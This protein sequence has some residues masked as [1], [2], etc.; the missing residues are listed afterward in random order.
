M[1]LQSFLRAGAAC[2]ILYAISPTAAFAEEGDTTSEE[3][4]EI[5]VIG[6]K[7]QQTIEASPATQASIDAPKIA[8]TINAVNVE[9]TLKYLPSLVVRKRHI[10]DTQ[11]PIATR[12]SGLGASARSLIYADGVLLSALIANNNTQGS[13]RWGFVGPDEVARID[14]QYGP[15]SAAYSG[16]SIGAVVNIT[17]RLPDSLEISANLLTNVQD[18][19]LYGTDSIYPTYQFA[20]AVG[21]R[22]GPLALFASVSRTDSKGH[23]LSYVTANRPAAPSAAGTATIG[24]YDDLN[25]TGAAIRVLGAGGIEHNV[26][27]IYKFKAAL[28]LSSNVRLTYVGGVFVDDTDS[29][30]QSFLTSQATGNAVYS[31]SLNLGGYAYSLSSTAFSSGIYHRSARHITHA[32]SATGNSSAFDWQVIA[33]QYDYDKDIQRTPTTAPPG[34]FTGGAG[35]IVDLDGTGWRTLDAKAAWRAGNNTL[36]AGGH[37]DR[38]AINSNRYVTTDWLVGNKGTLNLTS[39][40]KTRTAALWI[41]DVLQI[42]ETLSMTVGGRY[43]WWR[44]YDGVNFSLSPALSVNQPERKA[45][46]FSPKVSIEWR[47]ADRWRTRLSFGK[48]YRFPTVGELYQAITTGSTLT[49]PNP[50]LRPEKALSEELA[51]EYVTSSGTARISLFNESITDALISQSAPLVAGSTT[52]FNY[53]QNVDR[54]RVRGVELAVEQNDIL[55]RFDVSASATY[56]DSE[57]RKDVA[58]PAAVGKLLPSVPRWKASVVLTYRPDDA[59]SLTV[60]ARYAS[61]NYATL[62]NSDIIGNTYQGFYKYFVMDARAQFKVSDRLSLGLGV[63]NLNNDKYFLFHPFPQRSFTADVK[64]RY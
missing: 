50:D 46:G 49:V 17:T 31:G 35:Q 9:D 40:G 20:G 19:K 22:F 64:F 57:T 59:V 51:V 63:D 24:G 61:R 4:A 47:P 11:A 37:L 52:L 16:N 43:E 26:Q 33:T 1:K 38:Y 3:P 56:T 32:L 54:T 5:L 27:D 39:A 45:E 12:T 7:Q 2:T 53:V 42:G 28:D 6:L 62:D 44:A 29:T 13:P 60:A 34:A 30:V 23:P 21:N 36:S 48:A 10:G 55:P 15:Y 25:R 58:F 8:A 41:Q 14:V 18:F